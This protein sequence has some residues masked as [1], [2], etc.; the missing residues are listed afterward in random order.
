MIRRQFITLFGGAAAV[1][2]TSRPS[3]AHAQQPA[4]P[5]TMPVIGYLSGSSPVS[6][7]HLVTAFR[8]GLREAGYADGETVAIEYRWA[9]DQYDRLPDL[10]S[11]LVRRQVAVIAATDT[12]AAIA[13]KSVTAAVPIVFTIGGDPLREGL[14]VS[15]NRP[16]GNVTGVSFLSSELAGKQLGLLHQLLP[17]AT[18]IAVLVEPHWPLTESFV[19]D[20]RAAAPKIGKQIEVVS[21][22]TGADLDT[23]FASFAQ[24]PPDAL[25]VAPS[26]LVNNR[27]IQLATLTAYHR[28]PAIYQLREQAEA[29][30]L[31]SYGASFT[32]ANRLT[33]VYVGRI[34]KG[35]KPADLPVEQPTKFELVIN[36]NTARAFN[37][38]IPPSLLA[39]ADEV[40][41]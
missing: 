20:V 40:I 24:K 38:S 35:A 9:Q 7:A 36:L 28:V 37:L 16:G 22:N 41:E 15:L 33:G 29:G 34:L 25:L 39:I 32:D 12:A 21:A 19:A 3:T 4:K 14:V 13:A 10:A 31:M 8:R 30:G 11:E 17:A 5:T 26:A 1:W 6:R 23:V 27:R 2:S 18:R